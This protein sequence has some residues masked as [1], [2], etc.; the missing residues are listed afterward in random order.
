MSLFASVIAYMLFYW[1]LRHLA[2]S[3]LAAF[4]Y[5]QPMIATWLGVAL[6]GESVTQQLIWGGA[7]ILVGVYVAERRPW[8]NPGSRA[9]YLS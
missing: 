3:R 7:L 6:L 1:A 5:L 4:T 2:A 9:A 8:P